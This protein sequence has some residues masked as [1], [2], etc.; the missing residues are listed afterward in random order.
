MKRLI[1][2][3]VFLAAIILAGGCQT[4]Q[5]IETGLAVEQAPEGA[6]SVEQLAQRL[7]LVV[8]EDTPSLVTLRNAEGR[9]TLIPDPAGQAF[10]N[11]MRV[12]PEGGF[13]RVG[14]VLY[15]PETLEGDIRSALASPSA[16][17]T[18]QA[19][20][21]RP[22][23]A[24]TRPRLARAYRIVVDPGHGGKDPGTISRS[25]LMEKTVTLPVATELAR[26]LREDGFDVAMT[27]RSDVFI[28]LD[29]R[30][31]IANRFGADLFISIHADA[32]PDPFMRGFTVYTCQGA[33][34][35]SRGIAV[36]VA[37]ALRGSE[38]EG[39]GMRQANYRVLVMTQCPAILVE[40]GY[41]SNGLDAEMLADRA[42]QMQLARSIAD[43]IGEYFARQEP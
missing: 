33:A 14:G 42:V 6:I 1:P 31:A 20:A 41:L 18:Q 10:V 43:G 21:L 9:V 35:D 27:R 22:S 11:G 32:C 37:E 26:L 24:L 4:S 34:A 25:G 8:E 36:A 23:L 29:E 2:C 12:G 5:P 17:P 28:E 16:P 3:G 40:L 38:G 13:V 19:R 15:V 7:G 30:A 39:L